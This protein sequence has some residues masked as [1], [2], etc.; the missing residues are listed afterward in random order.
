MSD[1]SIISH[2]YHSAS[3]D[4]SPAIDINISKKNAN[5]ALKTQKIHFV[6]E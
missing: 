5:G 4:H 3:S 2:R 6:K 1:G